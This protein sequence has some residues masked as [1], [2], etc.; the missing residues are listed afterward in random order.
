MIKYIKKLILSNSKESSKRFIAIYSMLLVSF[1]VFVYTNKDNNV[2]VLGT[3]CS[4]VLTLVG[5]SAWHSVKSNKNDT[6]N[7]R[8]DS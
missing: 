6:T 5:V 4:F 7:D 2:L 1:V 3:L 8:R